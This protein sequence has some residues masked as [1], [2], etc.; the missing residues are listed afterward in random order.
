MATVELT[1]ENFDETIEGNDIV[2]LDFWAPWC[3]PCKTFGPIF[4]ETSEE[5]D[6]I[7]FGKINTEEQPALA[8]AFGIR[9]IPT[10]AVFRGQIPVF[11]QPGLVPKAGLEQLIEQVRELDM[12]E[13][14][15]EYEKQLAEHD[16]QHA[17]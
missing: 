2:L 13:V 14:R 16:K 9:S 4:E 3:G 12:D 1:T 5:H 7:V 15:E 8:Q 10:V 11:A 6:D 17:G